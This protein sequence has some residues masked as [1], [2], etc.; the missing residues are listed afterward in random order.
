MLKGAANIRSCKRIY[1]NFIY[2]RTNLHGVKSH[3]K[4]NGRNEKTPFIHHKRYLSTA[5]RFKHSSSGSSSYWLRALLTSGVVYTGVNFVL[6]NSTSIHKDNNHSNVV[7]AAGNSNKI[8]TRAEVAK[9]KTQKDGIWVTYKNVVYDITD[10]VEQHP[11]HVPTASSQIS[12]TCQAFPEPP[13][14]L[15][16]IQ[17]FC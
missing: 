4:F 15:K 1:R 2:N 7:E 3:A 13:R 6:S 14:K 8:Y 10:F 9:H 5:E 12:Q 16:S 17:L 11:E